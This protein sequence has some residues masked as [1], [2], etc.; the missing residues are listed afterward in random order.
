MDDTQVTLNAEERIYLSRALQMMAAPRTRAKL[1]DLE[2]LQAEI[3]LSD[4]DKEA[5]EFKSVAGPAPTMSFDRPKARDLIK[6]ITMTAWNQERIACFLRLSEL[7]DD[8]TRDYV[9]LYDKFWSDHLI[10]DR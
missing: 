3:D 10:R 5:I 8:L 1:A 7:N 9:S 2:G 6:A 4:E